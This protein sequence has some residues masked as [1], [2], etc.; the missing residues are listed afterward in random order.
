MN[1]NDEFVRSLNNAIFEMQAQTDEVVRVVMIKLLE[2]VVMRSAVGNPDIWAVNKGVAHYN[3]EV[4]EYNAQFKPR[5]RKRIKDGLDIKKPDGYVG[6]RYRGNW[7]VMFNSTTNNETG[8]IDAS[9]ADTLNAGKTLL[10]G[11]KAEDTY[12]IWIV[13]N[14]PYAMRLEFGHSKQQPTGNARIAINDFPRILEM[15]IAEVK[16]V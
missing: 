6:G 5:S 12:R 4:A 10:D 1:N 14:V 13:N 3:A 8:R 15:A 7:Q 16:K 11:Y 9:G 2:G